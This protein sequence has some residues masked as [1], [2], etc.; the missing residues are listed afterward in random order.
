MRI[1]I[2]VQWMRE[3]EDWSADRVR[4]ENSGD[5]Q[6]GDLTEANSFPPLLPYMS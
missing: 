6:P 3:E 4:L 2:M 5:I 1:K